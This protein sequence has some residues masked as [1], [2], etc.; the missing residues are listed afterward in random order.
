[1]AETGLF[2]QET[3]LFHAFTAFCNCPIE[4][5]LQIG[6]VLF[7]ADETV[8]HTGR[9]VADLYQTILLRWDDAGPIA[10]LVL[11]CE[12]YCKIGLDF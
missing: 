5:L 4:L 2:G 1:M 9:A 6:E 7:D 3:T 8:D 12:Q 10:G 11:I